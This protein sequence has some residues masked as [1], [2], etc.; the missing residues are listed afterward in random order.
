VGKE[1]TQF[2]KGVSGNPSGRP[3]NR[4]TKESIG[5]TI[6]R[7][8]AATKPTIE[9]IL[10]DPD[11]SNE[12]RAI[13]LMVQDVTTKPNKDNLNFL[14]DRSIGRVVEILEQTVKSIDDSDLEAIP[15]EVLLK[16]AAG[17]DP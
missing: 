7:L 12:E 9:A 6:S 16:L 17:G 1:A 10:A 8:F 4:L 5:T 11:T 15:R 13:A 14:L 2:R 3:K